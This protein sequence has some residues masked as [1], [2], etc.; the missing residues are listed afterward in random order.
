MSIVD[1]RVYAAAAEGDPRALG[2][3]VPAVR[4]LVTRRC[5]AE[6][7]ASI[8]LEQADVEAQRISRDI[9]SALPR[10]NGASLL[11]FVNRQARHDVARLSKRRRR[12]KEVGS[13]IDRLPD[14]E[15]EVLILRVLS[16]LSV[17]DT[18]V[19]LGLSPARVLL[20]QHRALSRLREQLRAG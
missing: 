18:A 13:L 7:S 20:D 12:S 15:R 14:D 10:H 8:G 19:A 11:A 4:A 5:R 16:G 17:A 2:T 3:V 6:L 1:E 9:I